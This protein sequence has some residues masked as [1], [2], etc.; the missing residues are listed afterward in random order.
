MI[1]IF[2]QSFILWLLTIVLICK[3][4]TNFFSPILNSKTI[5]SVVCDLLV[6]ENKFNFGNE[7]P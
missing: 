7:H 4:H 2:G 3:Y 1:C 5:C 6:I